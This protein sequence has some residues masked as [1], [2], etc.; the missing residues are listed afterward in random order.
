LV[1]LNDSNGFV[2]A[3]CRFCFFHPS[4]LPFV[5][6]NK[7]TGGC[8]DWLLRKTDVAAKATVCGGFPLQTPTHQFLQKRS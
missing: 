3:I 7:R 4:V 5:F 8:A 2:S 1:L 6:G